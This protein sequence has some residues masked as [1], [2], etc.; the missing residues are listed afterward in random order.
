[1]AEWLSV[2][3]YAYFVTLRRYIVDPDLFEIIRNGRI[4]R[5]KVVVEQL[6]ILRTVDGRCIG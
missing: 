6:H 1:V 3:K 5:D 4:C 2:L